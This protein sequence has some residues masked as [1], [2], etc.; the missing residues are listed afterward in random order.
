MSQTAS[1]RLKPG[2]RARR[3]GPPA[4]RDTLAGLLTGNGH[5]A[6]LAAALVRVSL[7]K[8]APDPARAQHDAPPPARAHE[9]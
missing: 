2:E 1:T 8:P 3:A 9:G 6:R 4:D 5:P 7:A